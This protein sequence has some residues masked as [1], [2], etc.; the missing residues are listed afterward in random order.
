MLGQMYSCGNRLHWRNYPGKRPQ[1]HRWYSRARR[2]QVDAILVVSR[3]SPAGRSDDQRF[4]V[5]VLDTVRDDDTCLTVVR[6]RLIDMVLEITADR[7][8]LL[9]HEVSIHTV[10]HPIR[11]R[12]SSTSSTAQERVCQMRCC[13]AGQLPLLTGSTSTR[14]VL[15]RLSLRR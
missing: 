10:V 4:D 6:I 1:D 9:S 13:S 3:R 2:Q 15:L 12:S 14:L 5:F 7:D 8:R 11:S